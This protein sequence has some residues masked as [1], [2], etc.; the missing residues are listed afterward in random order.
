MIDFR[1]NRWMRGFVFFFGIPVGVTPVLLPPHQSVLI[2]PLT[3][4][5][6]YAWRASYHYLE[7]G[8]SQSVVSEGSNAPGTGWLAAWGVH[9]VSSRYKLMV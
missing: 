1:E 8:S 6:D 4:A 2:S 3:L 9:L 5:R 7:H